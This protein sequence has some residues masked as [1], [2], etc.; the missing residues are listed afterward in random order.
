MVQ[1]TVAM[2]GV[3]KAALQREIKPLNIGVEKKDTPFSRMLERA[4]DKGSKAKSTADEANKVQSNE[5]AHDDTSAIDNPVKDEKA[6]G[7]AS[8]E[9]KDEKE[10][11]ESK[12]SE[13]LTE[14]AQAA[15]D[16]DVKDSAKTAQ[17]TEA[18]DVAQKTAAKGLDKEQTV[19][20]AMQTGNDKDS[21]EVK[22]LPHSA[23]DTKMK[24]KEKDKIGSNKE[25]KDGKASSL[26][27]P[28]KPARGN[29]L[30]QEGDC[31]TGSQVGGNR[32]D[33]NA[34]AGAVIADVKA[35]ANVQEQ[36]FD[37]QEQDTEIAA[38]TGAKGK[39]EGSNTVKSN[40]E[41]LKAKAAKKK[42]TLDKDGKI[43]V[44][45]QRSE[46]GKA[47][48]AADLSKEEKAALK[49][50]SNKGEAQLNINATEATKQNIASSSTQSAA[51]SSSVFQSMVENS[52][53]E[54]TP[55]IVKAG[56][57]LLRDNNTGTINLVMHPENLGNVRI[58]LHLQDNAVSGQITVHSEEAYNAFRHS[59]TALSQAFNDS[60]FDSQGFTVS[61]SGADAS[62]Q[63]QEAGQRQAQDAQYTFMSGRAERGYDGA[64]HFVPADSGVYAS[65]YSVNIVA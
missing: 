51:S 60:G 59:A 22:R 15:A 36:I 18:K 41:E 2:E 46:D 14:D 48:A 26:R 54:N 27:E 12:D 5:A 35:Q 13:T 47:R 24:G 57:L 4:M 20:R 16:K 7:I 19:G 50:H 43:A 34:G 9:A 62:G 58:V 49:V 10:I 38:V 25:G 64:A 61:Y 29:R 28:A 37:T 23:T 56:T 3:D 21:G 8:S 52:V 45:D 55:E 53:R 6:S 32:N 65:D 17:K 33:E 40:V 30:S 44:I 42:Q 39:T 63:G 31:F 1:M 11:A